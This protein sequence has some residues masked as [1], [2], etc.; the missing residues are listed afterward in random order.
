MTAHQR[1]R[2]REVVDEVTGQGK[3]ETSGAGTP[4]RGLSGIFQARG[5]GGSGGS[6]RGCEN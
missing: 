6:S 5:D 2:G 3:E 1:L 4:V